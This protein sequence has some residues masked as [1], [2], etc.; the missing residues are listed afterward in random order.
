MNKKLSP[1][2]INSIKLMRMNGYSFKEISEELGIAKSTAFGYSHDIPVL[3]KKERVD[4]WDEIKK[5]ENFPQGKIAEQDDYKSIIRQKE[6]WKELHSPG[7]RFEGPTDLFSLDELT[8]MMEVPTD[9]VSPLSNQEWYDKYIAPYVLGK[10]SYLSNTQKE[11]LSFLEK[12]QYVLAE[13]WRGMGKSVLFVGRMSRLISENR[14][15]NYFVQCESTERAVERVTAVRDILA[16]NKLLIADYGY[17]AHDK[18]YRGIKGTWRSDAFTVKRDTIQIDPSLKAL[19]WKDAR[20]LGG[21]FHGGYFDDPWSSKLEENN[22]RNKEKWFNWYDSTGVGCMEEGAFQHFVCTRKGLYDIYRDLEDRG[23]FAV[24]KKPAILEYPTDWEYIKD[25]KG[26]ITGVQINSSDGIIADDCNGRFSMEFFLM[27]KANVGESKF[28]MEW[29]L[30]P[31]PPT[32]RLFA[33]ENLRYINSLDD[34]YDLFTDER[35]YKTSTKV[36][37]AMDMAMG[38]SESAHYTALAIV[39]YSKPNYYILE[40]YYK[41]GASTK[42]KAEMINRAK[43]DFPHLTQVFIE[44]DFHQSEYIEDMREHVDSV[45]INE[46]LSRHEAGVVSKSIDIGELEKKHA[47]IYSQIDEVLETGHLFVNKRMMGYDLFMTEL[48]EFPRSK[49]DDGLDAVGNVLSKL[50]RTRALIWGIS[51]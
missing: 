33:I 25:D 15:N 10:G 16:S 42:D 18:T 48:R 21:H 6:Y 14:E 43:K 45:K 34:F 47:R 19:S 32:G 20:M 37:G 28:A 26:I 4:P 11:L 46:V 9:Y 13:V 17:L 7:K 3:P 12:Y 41:K 40:V 49:Y 24:Y 30:N 31:L 2:M 27:K 35:V 38:K 22:E 51:G 23:M 8:E 5:M 39:A 29:Q 1:N 50:K 36:Y 44:A